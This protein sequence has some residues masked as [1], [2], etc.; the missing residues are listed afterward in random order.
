MRHPAVNQALKRVEGVMGGLSPEQRSVVASY[1]AKPDEVGVRNRW[2]E[3]K[4]CY[5]SLPEEVGAA[6]CSSL[7]SEVQ[8]EYALLA[9][10]CA[11]SV[12]LAFCLGP[13]GLVLPSVARLYGA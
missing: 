10:S 6:M 9:N 2:I 1:R 11:G 3:M 7:A 5:A 4:I 8:Q 12:C 13:G